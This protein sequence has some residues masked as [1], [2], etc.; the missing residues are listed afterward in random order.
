MGMDL[1]KI[2]DTTAA[3]AVE[4]KLLVTV[5]PSSY[6]DKGAEGIMEVLKNHGK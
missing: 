1:H 4:E 5:F 6:Y 3:V 2:L